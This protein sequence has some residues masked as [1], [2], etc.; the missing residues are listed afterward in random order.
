V[1]DI[2]FWYIERGILVS[3]GGSKK[4]LHGKMIVDDENGRKNHGH[5][6][7]LPSANFDRERPTI[8]R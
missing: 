2:S 5:P 6:L 8:E 7:Q 1:Y 3:P 4:A